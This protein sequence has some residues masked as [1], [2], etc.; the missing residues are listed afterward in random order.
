MVLY[1]IWQEVFRA[2]A[3]WQGL[4]ALQQYFMPYG[5]K[6][7][8]HMPFG[9]G[10]TARAVEDLA[11]REP[12]SSQVVCGLPTYRLRRHRPVRVLSARLVRGLHAAGPELGD[13]H[14]LCLATP[15]H[16]PPLMNA[17]RAVRKGLS[18][19]RKSHKRCTLMAQAFLECVSLHCDGPCVFYV[20]ALP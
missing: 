17:I 20:Q 16:I 11:E 15:Q 19:K 7:S 4:G 3:F 13:T 2:H 9:K 18:L 14:G 5:K 12:P 10:H 6:Y 1:A 8:R